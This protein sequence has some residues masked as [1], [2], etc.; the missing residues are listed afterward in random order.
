MVFFITRESLYFSIL[1][2][3]SFWILDFFFCKTCRTLFFN[4]LLGWLFILK[5]YAF[6]FRLLFALWF[7]CFIFIRCWY[8]ALWYETVGLLYILPWVDFTLTWL[9]YYIIII[10]D[11]DQLIALYQGAL[12]LFYCFKIILNHSQDGKEKNKFSSVKVH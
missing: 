4:N 8:L 10:Q 9:S 2:N 7:Y 6:L 3:L 1:G 12:W 5:L 11:F